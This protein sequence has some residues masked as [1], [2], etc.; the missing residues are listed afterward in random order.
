VQGVTHS[1]SD[2]VLPRFK[3]MLLAFGGATKGLAEVMQQV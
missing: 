2:M 3:H 1:F